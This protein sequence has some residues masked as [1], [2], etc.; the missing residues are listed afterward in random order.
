MHV[1]M[2]E[3]A[4]AMFDKITENPEKFLSL[5]QVYKHRA[6]AD[7]TQP[8]IPDAVRAASLQLLVYPSRVKAL[9]YVGKHPALAAPYSKDVPPQ[10]KAALQQIAAE[11]RRRHVAGCRG[12]SPTL[13]A[14]ANRIETAMMEI[15]NE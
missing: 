12:P 3:A 2:L 4:Q 1:E 10:G 11:M 14:W 8:G 7:L 5:R 6:L 9:R 13:V 15:D